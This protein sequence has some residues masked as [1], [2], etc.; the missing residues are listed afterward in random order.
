MK[1]THKKRYTDDEGRVLP[2]V[3]IISFLLFAAAFGVL[4]YL[5]LNGSLPEPLERSLHVSEEFVDTDAVDE[6]LTILKNR[7]QEIRT[8]HQSGVK[9]ESLLG[10]LDNVKKQLINLKEKTSPAIQEKIR[11]VVDTTDDLIKGVRDQITNVG[12]KFDDVIQ[13]IESAAQTLRSGKDN[14]SI[15]D[16]EEDENEGT[17][18]SF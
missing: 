9:K 6:K 18:S 12:E 15:D 2:A 1:Q 4:F 8:Q 5:S 10:E 3:M 11:S 14:T 16:K 17:E 7:I 13:G